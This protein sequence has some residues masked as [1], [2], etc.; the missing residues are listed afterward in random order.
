MYKTL[1]KNMFWKILCVWLRV[2]LQDKISD[3]VLKILFIY[4]FDREQT[5]ERERKRAQAGGRGTGRRRSRLPAEQGACP[6][7]QSQEILT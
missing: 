7:A 2:C 5:R 3:S 6:G 1:L 4:L